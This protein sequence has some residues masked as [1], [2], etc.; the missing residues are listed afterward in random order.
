[1]SHESTLIATLAVGFVLALLLGM[2]ASRLKMPPLVGFL[3]AGVVMSPYTPGFSGDTHLASELAEVGV[4][5]LM[6]GVGMHFSIEDLLA[7][8][9]IAIPGAVLQIM[10]ATLL[11]AVLVHLW[12]WGWG[13][14]IIFGL[15]LSVASTVVLLRM[16]EERGLLASPDGRIA[17][18]WLVVEDLAMVLALV[19]LP[20]FAQLAGGTSTGHDA[21]P[22][23]GGSLLWSVLITIGK[24]AL[25]SV[26]ALVVG[27]RVMPWLL[28]KVSQTGSRELFTL[29]VLAV[30]LGI[31]YGSAE[32]FDVSFAL[33]A[34][35]AG[36]ILNESELS[37]QAATQS[38]PLQDAFAVLFFVSVGM[39]FDPAILVQHP[40]EV[41][42][43]VLVIVVGKSLAAFLIVLAFGRPLR[44]ALLI[45][46][47]LGQI[48]E[49]SFI[50]A[51]LG[52]EFG[53]LPKEGR[54]LI[55]AGAILSIALNPLL[56]RLVGAMSPASAQAAA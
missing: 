36:M 8:R 19:L 32:L 1:M 2:G 35:F 56:F 44:T 18:G 24:V 10:A 15:A 29:A 53:L 51:G 6:F 22:A 38:L 23:A 21:A 16:L 48:G 4:I 20:P 26:L 31:A 28:R 11:A 50:L 25:F 33:G 41:L 54:D 55:L 3:L 45:S 27:R 40:L 34:F 7:V 39:L 52:L 30:S 37:H 42:A 47:S 13:A 14:A 12:G 5:L 43:T 17:V 49:F 9:R 46:A